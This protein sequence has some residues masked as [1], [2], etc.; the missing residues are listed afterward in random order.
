MTYHVV[1]PGG[2]DI[3]CESAGEGPPVLL[4][5][6]FGANRNITWRNTGWIDALTR[7]GHRV[8]AFDCRGH[9]QSAK[10]QA[11]GYYDEGTM[12][13]DALAALA[14]AG[15]KSACVMGYSMGSQLAV[16]LMHDH[17]ESVTR[18]VLAGMGEI[19]FH[20][21][22]EINESI[23]QGL[24]TSDPSAI[25][26][27]I[28]REFRS[29]CERAGDDLVAMAACMRRPRYSFSRDE[30]GLLPQPVLV[31]CGS[32]DN[33]AG[34]PEPLAQAFAHGESLVVP[35]RNHHS[36]VGDPVYRNAVI[37]FFGDSG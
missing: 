14:G 20:P 33:I 27:P 10:P 13:A 2:I 16:R 28:A 37:R 1:G 3:A 5:H 29:F 34:S 9:G 17:P 4:I 30:L 22:P 8:I 25:T 32:V 7:A 11:P 21:T 6:G 12:A 15:L 19:Y 36:T 18:C 31:V 23:A 35:K 24:E 26:I